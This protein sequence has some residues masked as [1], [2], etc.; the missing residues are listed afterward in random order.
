LEH[1][2]AHY[3][4]D[5][6]EVREDAV[7][8][9]EDGTVRGVVAPED[10]DGSVT[11]L[12]RV[13]VVPGRVNAHSHAFQRAI[14]GRTEFLEAGREEDDFWSWREK[15][16]RAALSLEA[17]QFE[18]IARFA[19][20]E[21]AR[22]GYTTVGEFHYV[23][24][25]PDGEP[26]AD[27]NE[28]AKRTVRAAR[29]VGLR[30]ALLRTA[31]HRAGYQ[32]E[33]N[34][35]QRRFLEPDLETYLDRIEALA[36]HVDGLPRA[37]VGLAP[38][39]IRAV[40]GD[41]L[42]GIAEFAEQRD[43]PVHIHACE[44]R[45]E[46]DQS[47]DEYGATPIEVFDE[48]GLLSDRTIIIHATHASEREIELMADRGSSVCACP[49]TERNLGDGFL[50]ARQLV[51]RGVPICL[52]TDSHADI[53]PWTEMRL[54]DYHER[55]RA[56][57]RNVLAEGL[58]ADRGG[59]MVTA[60]RL[61]PMGGRHGARALGLEPAGLQAGDP[62]D[63]TAVDLDHLSLTGTAPESLLSDLV[64]SIPPDAVSETIVGGERIVRDGAHPNETEI[65]D[66]FV[67][68]ARDVFE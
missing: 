50:P 8:A 44:Q 57:R 39:S 58:A 45:A 20:L 32:Q 40:P 28:L 64:F 17:D 31:Y 51:D 38:H 49:T 11:D 13:A 33:P 23:H 14:R 30:I 66:A 47:V 54:V 53:D 65:A 59:R 21:M 68:A 42:E 52:G 25:D 3:L 62:A 24:H 61:W 4:L 1:Y 12:G 27:P 9:V 37:S 15:M 19:F 34:P 43:L 48:L 2:R 46:L 22:A 63:F 36:D 5:G 35:R 41:W 18:A 16:Y 55:L 56:E 7:V 26:Y 29:D 67:R 10:V 60:E 6:P